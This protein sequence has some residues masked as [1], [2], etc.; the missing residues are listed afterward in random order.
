M[1]KYQHYF[2]ILTFIS[3]L[4]KC[5]R[6]IA[7]N[8]FICRYIIFYEQLKFCAQLVEYVKSFITSGPVAQ[9][10]LS[11]ARNVLIDFIL[12]HLCL[13]Y[14]NILLNKEFFHKIFSM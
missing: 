14:H 6:L 7:R 10:K 2:G 1:L 4:N 13:M 8:V 9:N 11:P 12:I 3:M 5:E